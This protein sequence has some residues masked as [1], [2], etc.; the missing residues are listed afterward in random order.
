MVLDNGLIDLAPPPRPDCEPT[1]FSSLRRGPRRPFLPKN[2]P[3]HRTLPLAGL[4]L[5]PMRDTVHMKAMRAFP[6]H[7]NSLPNQPNQPHTAG[8]EREGDPLIGHSSP[9]NRH[10]AHVPSNCTVQMPQ[11]SSAVAA[12]R[13]HFHSAT[14]WYAVKVTFMCAAAAAAGGA[15]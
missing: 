6:N 12:G 11:V 13:S 10:R 2:L 14:E 7:F 4:L 3:T 9:G 1:T 5:Q 8:G 15:A